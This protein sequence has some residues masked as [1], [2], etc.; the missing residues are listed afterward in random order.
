MENKVAS[1][2]EMKMSLNVL[3]HLGLNLYSNIPAVLSEAVANAYDADAE[4][5]KININE[6]DGIITIQDDGHGMTSKELNDKFLL[7]GYSRRKNGEQ[8]SQRFKRPVMGR[9]GIGKLSLFS[10]AETIE[11]HTI[12]NG[13]KS[14][15]RMNKS[16]IEDEILK[17]DVY[18]PEELSTS[19]VTITKGTKIILTDFK[20]Q[21]NYASSYL[22]Q[23]L[24]RRFSVLGKEHNFEVMIDDSS[25]KVE[26]RNFFNKV[27]FIWI[28]GEGNNKITE[29]FNFLRVNQLNGDIDGKPYKISGWIGSVNKPSDLKE[30]KVNNNKVSIVVRGKLAQE[31][32]L[33]DFSEGGIYFDYLIGEIHADF[34][35]DDDKDDIAT[36]SRQKINEDD[37]R[38][39]VLQSHIYKLLKEIQK[40]WTKFRKEVS[41]ERAIETA[42]AVHPGLEVWYESL[43]SEPRR[44]HARELFGTIETFHFDENEPDAREKKKDLYIQGIIAFEKLRLRD[45]LHELANI[46]SPDHLKLSQ[47]FTDLTD[48]EANL[49]YDIAATRV[50]VI[51]NFQNKL[52]NNEKEKLLQKYLFDH[53]WLLDPSWERP[54][55]GSEVMEQRIEKEFD[56]VT[57]TLTQEER[58]GRID[59]KYRTAAGKHIIIELKRY[60]PSYRIKPS[61]LF[62]QVDK[63]TTALEKCLITTDQHPRIESIVILGDTLSKEDFSKAQKILDTINARIIHYDE[64][65][66][67]SLSSYSDYLD[68]Q[69]EISSLRKIIDDLKF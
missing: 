65:I 38:Y 66:S 9:K 51:K 10:I 18:H 17:S 19:Q 53:L 68:K 12:K 41:E 22:R 29:N 30:G 40:V 28:I 24:A 8:F 33:E 27:E 7:V 11:V 59:I 61:D 62:A 32:I 42:K 13:E 39:K 37:E 56:K 49:F 57:A 55:A 48:L 5:V 36:S 25:I 34:I 35:D 1:K 58:N 6:T 63:Y 31:D 52:D 54:T 3:N 47:I 2:Y 60:T 50:E 14:A 20:R 69:K 46:K 44:K 4:T 43:K 67:K 16:K 21:I 26:D 64:L 15:L 23:R 45:S